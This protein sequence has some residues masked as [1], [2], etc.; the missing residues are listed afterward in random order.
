M[1]YNSKDKTADAF[2]NLEV[3]SANGE[4]RKLPKGVALELSN[5]LQRSMINAHNKGTA[6]GQTVEFNLVGTVH[7]VEDNTDKD[8][9]DFGF[10]ENVV[11]EP[12]EEEYDLDPGEQ[13]AG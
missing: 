3:V 4:R 8:D 1:Q 2:L 6:A 9:I 7:I 11:S 5:L 13:Q 10:G 12:T